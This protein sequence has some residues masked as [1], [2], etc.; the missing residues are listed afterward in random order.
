[1]PTVEIR[2]ARVHYADSGT[3]PATVLLLH[4]FP[5]NAGMWTEQIEALSPR[6]RVVAPDGPGFGGSTLRPAPSAMQS[7][8]SDALELL[9]RLG[10]GRASVVGLSMGGYVAFELFRQRPALVRALV[11]CDTRPGAD[12]ADGAKGREA[13]AKQA[14]ENGLPWVADQLLPKLLGPQADA[15]VVSAVRARIEAGTAVGVAAA[16]RGMAAR[17]DS[18]QTLSSIRCP[19]LV[20][21]GAEDVLTPPAESRRMAAAIAGSRL[22]ELPGVGHL[23][24]LEAPAAFNDALLDFLARLPS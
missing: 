11:L 17:P 6:Y 20:L 21:V 16:Q 10:V 14:I 12:T 5:L 8:A 4:A 18:T 13:F 7:L 24:N 2:G 19:T 23:S 3:G 9:G 1:M 22:V 15:K